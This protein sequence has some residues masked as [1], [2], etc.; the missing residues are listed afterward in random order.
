MK[1]NLGASYPAG[2]YRKGWINADILRHDRIQVVA[3]G[4]LLPFKDNVFTEAHCVHVLEHLTREKQLPMLKELYRVVERG[5]AVF[6]EVPNFIATC[7]AIL[8][9]WKNSDYEQ[10]RIWTV[11]V[12]GKSERDGMA[13]HWGFNTVYM[14]ELIKKVGFSSFEYPEEMISPHHKLEPVLL[15]KAIK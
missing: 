15:I 1:L 11:S 2:K 4:T 3:D 13:H 9:A 5:A 8:R 12:Y 6:I 10:V 14:E 7:G